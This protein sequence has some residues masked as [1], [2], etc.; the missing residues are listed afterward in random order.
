M[1]Q[2]HYNDV[3][4]KIINELSTSTNVLEKYDNVTYNITLYMLDRKKEKIVDENIA[5]NKGFISEHIDDNEK[6]I[7]AQSG[8]TLNF[9]IDSLLIK[10]VY[11][12]FNNPINVHAYEMNLKIKEP[13]GAN[14]TNALD[15]S[16]LVS[17]YSFIITVEVQ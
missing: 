16:A 8:V 11:G 5:N 4:K 14:L 1:A 10:T 6:I 17:L 12:N 7:I 9:V 15:L 13:M 3:V 2:I